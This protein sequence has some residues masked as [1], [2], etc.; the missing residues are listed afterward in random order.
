MRYIPCY[1]L[2]VNNEYTPYWK[3]DYSYEEDY[4]HGYTTEDSYRTNYSN[5]TEC[6]YDL[7]EKKIVLGIVKDIYQ[8]PKYQVGQQVLVET[9]SSLYSIDS[10]KEIVYQTYEST[11]YLAKDLDEYQ[12]KWYFTE[13]E[14]KE[15]KLNELYEFRLWEPYYLLESGKLIKYNHQL[16]QLV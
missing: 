16:A 12:L 10:I 1:A 15:I 8:K 6:L 2:K 9:G 7:V 13:D 14:I 11:C 3:L 5:L 4:G